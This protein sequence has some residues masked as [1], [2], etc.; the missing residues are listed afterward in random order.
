MFHKY[1]KVD[2]TKLRKSCES[3]IYVDI[4]NNNQEYLPFRG[5]SGNKGVLT[6]QN[7]D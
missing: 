3:W 6:W 4:D 7:S 2:K 5:I 1:L